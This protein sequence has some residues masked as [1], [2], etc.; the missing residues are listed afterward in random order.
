[1]STACAIVNI[2]MSSLTDEIFTYINSK[3]SVFMAKTKEPDGN[4][5]FSFALGNK[6]ET[7]KAGFSPKYTLYNACLISYL[8]SFQTCIDYIEK[9]KAQLVSELDGLL[10]ETEASFEDF[11]FSF[12]SDKQAKNFFHKDMFNTSLDFCVEIQKQC[13]NEIQGKIEMFL[14]SPDFSEI[15]NNLLKELSKLDL[16]LDEKKYEDYEADDPFFNSFTHA[17]QKIIAQWSNQLLSDL[18]E[19]FIKYFTSYIADSLLK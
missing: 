19:K 10:E 12:H 3:I 4:R 16:N 1:M 13:N 8:N 6:E 9:L 17:I 2:I 5:L 15:I 11:K 7:R 14:H 18:F